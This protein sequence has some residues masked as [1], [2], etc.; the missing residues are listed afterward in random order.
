MQAP[1][2]IPEVHPNDKA[3]LR[4][5]ASLARAKAGDEPVSFLRRTE[6]ISSSVRRSAPGGP[7]RPN[8]ANRQPNKRPAPEVDDSPAAIR[9][10]IMHD[11]DW[12]KKCLEDTSR[13][14]NP[15]P[16]R[17]AKIADSFRFAPDLDAFPDAGAYVEVKF[18]TNPVQGHGKYDDRMLNGALKPCEKTPA[19]EMAYA[20]VVDAHERDPDNNSKP[21]PFM[22]YDFYLHKRGDTPRFR[23]KFDVDNPEKDEDGLY[24]AEGES[25]PCFQ[26]TRLRGYE[27]TKEVEMD[28]KT[29]YGTQ[30]FIGFTEEDDIEAEKGAWYYP[31]MQKSVIRPQRQRAIDLTRGL[32]VG[33]GQAT[34]EQLDVTIEDPTDELREHMAKFGEHPR[35]WSDEEEEEEEE[36]VD[37]DGEEA[38]GREDADAEGDDEE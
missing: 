26:F 19:E 12:A 36:E 35:G 30:L 24:T 34:V 25:G 2:E 9:R 37:E 22:N 3:L 7:T 10:K 5:L 29:K 8:N 20:Q 23:A 18:A 6:Y 28:H 31:V 33:D 38:G 15:F 21:P 16:K 11:F 13:V 27:T 1:S 14:K 32:E 17:G 4:P